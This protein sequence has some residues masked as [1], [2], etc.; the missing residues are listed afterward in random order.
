MRTLV[1]GLAILMLAACSS[2]RSARVLTPDEREATARAA[3]IALHVP[4]VAV[5]AWTMSPTDPLAAHARL[6][7]AAFALVHAG[8]HYRLRRNPAYEFHAPLSIVL[9][10]GAA[11]CGGGYLGL[12]LLG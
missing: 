1:L 2:T 7:V 12:I 3:F 10:A 6:A 5:L 11:L 9:I 8:L 4:L